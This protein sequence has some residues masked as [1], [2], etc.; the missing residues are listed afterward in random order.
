MHAAY[1]QW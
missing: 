1:Q